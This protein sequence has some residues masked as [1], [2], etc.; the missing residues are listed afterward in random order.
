M[1]NTGMDSYYRDLIVSRLID[2]G[3]DTRFTLRAYEFVYLI[4]A[5]LEKSS[6]NTEYGFSA[7]DVVQTSEKM[8]VALYGPIAEFVLADMGIKSANDIGA[9]IGNLVDLDIFVKDGFYGNDDF[10]EISKKPLFSKA[11]FKP[12]DIEN[13]KI[14]EDS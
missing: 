5:V 9:I 2:T 7:K 6:L 1:K 10:A 8:A 11:Q 12:L 3:R 4:F 14:F 13:L